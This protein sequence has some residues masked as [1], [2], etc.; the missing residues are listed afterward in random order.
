MQAFTLAFGAAA[1]VAVP[2]AIFLGVA[3][4]AKRRRERRVSEQR[5]SRD[6]AIELSTGRRRSSAEGT[7]GGESPRRRRSGRGRSSRRADTGIDLF[8][9]RR[10]PASEDAP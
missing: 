3:H 4:R 1:V 8:A 6:T 5:R 10:E 2:L 7:D 9:G